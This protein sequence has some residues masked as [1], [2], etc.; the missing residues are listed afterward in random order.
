MSISTHGLY[1]DGNEAPGH[2][3]LMELINPANG[4]VHAKI[5]CASE[6]DVDQA[7]RLADDRFRNGKWAS[8]NS[9]KRGRIL[10]NMANLVR[11]KR[12]ELGEI[13]SRNT[14]KPLG[15][16]TGE[17]VAVANCFEYYAGA[18]N[19]FFGQ[20]IPGAANGSLMTFREPLG[21]CGLI[22]PWNFPLII[23]AWKVAP[24]LAMGNTVVIKPAEITPLSALAL[25]DIAKEAGL[26]DGVLNV[27]PGPGELTGEALVG[28]PLVRK[29][30]FT[31][32]TEVGKRVM[33]KAA[34]DIK[35]VS[36]ELG[37]KSASIVFA[38][39][40][41]D[42]CVKS[43]IFAVYDNTGQDCCARSRVLVER[44]IFEAFVEQFIAQAKDLKLGLPE[45]T[46]TQIGPLISSEQRE[47]VCGYLDI[48]D[49]EGARRLTGGETP[50]DGPLKNGYYLSPVVYVDV[51][52]EMRIMQEEVFGPVVSI[53][54]FD[55]ETEAVAI[56]NNSNYG[57][58]GSLWTRD[59]ARAMRVSRALET[60]MLSVNTSSSVH[61][62]APFGGVKQSGIGREQGMAALD[63]YS[64]Y[65]S[66]FISE[67]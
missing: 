1:I 33:A 43:S 48:A 35:R 38:D 3:E 56:A 57:L 53:M 20:T 60:G 58:S 17:M 29:I 32:S 22:V 46:G 7:V 50:A 5:S 9:R 66:V 28:H 16:A 47:R 44:P 49:D 37:G 4:E 2:G 24:A 51:E 26:P 6:A 23:T 64:E 52:P 45:E 25:A 15:N 61:I 67:E 63:H 11:Q 34:T 27:V 55:G 59:V 19:K 62:E 42:A 40:N 12:N 30:S 18:V 13:E 8:M 14:G 39:A 31:G 65:K 36:L 21:V 54:P 41:L 10:Q